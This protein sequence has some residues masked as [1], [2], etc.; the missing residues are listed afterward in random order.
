MRKLTILLVALGIAWLAFAHIADTADVTIYALRDSLLLASFAALFYTQSSP[1]RISQSAISNL[2]SPILFLLVYLLAVA[3]RFWRLTD[4]PADCIG[5]E[6]TRALQLADVGAGSGLQNWLAAWFWQMTQ[7]GLFS[8]R[9]AGVL[10]GSASVLAFYGLARQITSP[11]GALLG[12]LLLAISPWHLWLSRSADPAN[13]LLLAILLI[14]WSTLALSQKRSLW[15]G[16]G[17]ILSLSLLFI[18]L[19]NVATITNPQSA[20][21]NPQFLNSLF[22]ASTNDL[23]SPFVNLPLLAPLVAALALCGLGV[24][25]GRIRRL[26]FAL[27]VV[28]SLVLGAAVWQEILPL[29]TLLPLLFVW[30]TLAIDELITTLST[31]WQPLLKPASALSASLIVLFLFNGRAT[32]HLIDQLDTLRTSEANATNGAMARYLLEHQSNEAQTYFFAPP[33]LR[34]D[35][36]ARL[37]AGQLL[38]T[39][40][41]SPID[42]SALPILGANSGEM[43]FLVP[44]EDVAL[45]SLLQQLYP[46]AQREDQRGSEG[47]VLFSVLRVTPD[48]L[49]AQQ[50]MPLIGLSATY[51]VGDQPQGMALAQRV[52]PLPGYPADFPQPYTVL[53][54]GKVAAVRSGETLLGIVADGIVTMMVDGIQVIAPTPAGETT[55]N[56][57]TNTLH[58]GA[59]YLERGWHSLEIRYTP[60]TPLEP[61]HLYWQVPGSGAAPLSSQFLHPTEDLADQPP[62]PS[63][64]SLPLADERLGSVDNFALTTSIDLWQASLQPPTFAPPPLVVEKAWQTSAGCGTGN[65]QLNHPHGAAID[66]ASRR[67]FVADTENRRI[68]VYSLAGEV[69]QAYPSDL[70]EGPVDVAVEPSGTLLVLDAMQNSVLRLDS[71]SGAITQLPLST[72]FYRP[73]GLAVDT[74][75]LILVADTGG[76]RVVVLNGA[77][78]MVGEFGGMDKALGRGQPVDAM[79]LNNIWW[80]V[81]A[82]NGRI[83]NLG[84][85][86][87][88]GAL[89]FNNTLDGPQMAVLPS[90]SF[91]V[92]DPGRGQILYFAST[93]QPLRQLSGQHA[94][95][96]G[97]AA[98]V[99]EGQT[100]LSVVDS[101]ACSLT[102]WRVLEL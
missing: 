46:L 81:S 39:D 35:P 27:I 98:A 64:Q 80:A 77:G 66:L 72:S 2:Q 12:T 78:E 3:L 70:F 21:Q 25:L 99:I 19:R 74:M 48:A 36:A 51:Y 16:F 82:E 29:T 75:G 90:G 30:A 26:N 83:W 13:V 94:V 53:W 11:D 61:L 54:R 88:L 58:E 55:Q 62:L 47:A 42:P 92:S 7:D 96:T 31:S 71:T 67:I 86:G 15:S 10:I 18:E 85:L 59:L 32:L 60:K 43:L 28:A 20:I 49:A 41:V 8:L 79:A 38:Q 34:Y 89:S 65:G 50:P 95:P 63:G 23:A 57:V 102:L 84:T 6:C 24:A 9:L 17:F 4:L 45:L 52:D 73:R 93:G 100:Y 5:E 37:L 33:S 44:I 91:F 56:E 87:S 76:A 22:H 69:L 1:S 68:M 40:R 101:A 97:V 14:L